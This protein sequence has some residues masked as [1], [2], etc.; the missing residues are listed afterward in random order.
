[1]PFFQ[2]PRKRVDG[3]LFNAPDA[4]QCAAALMPAVLQQLPALLGQYQSMAMKRSR[5]EIGRCP[6][7]LGYAKQPQRRNPADQL[8]YQAL[9]I[10]AVGQVL[11]CACG[12]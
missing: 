5:G 9:E 12:F 2:L 1:M 7:L 8:W 10:T 3:L 11:S 6:V 4:L